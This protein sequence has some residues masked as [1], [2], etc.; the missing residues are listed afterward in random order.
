MGCDRPTTAPECGAYGG[1]ISTSSLLHVRTFPRPWAHPSFIH[2]IPA[3]QNSNTTQTP[4][5]P[6]PQSPFTGP[7]QRRQ[8]LIGINLPI[9]HNFGVGWI[10]CEPPL[11]TLLAEDATRPCTP[12]RRSTASIRLVKMPLS[13]ITFL[14]PAIHMCIRRG[15]LE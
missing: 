4:P 15:L 9:A 7:I 11:W 12:R 2:I 6:S 13:Q 8:R 14:H 1:G 3:S 10:Y 5:L